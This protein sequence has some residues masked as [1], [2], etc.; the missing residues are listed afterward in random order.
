MLERKQQSR[1]FSFLLAFPKH[2]ALT[3]VKY[4]ARHQLFRFHQFS[5]RSVLENKIANMSRYRYI[6]ASMRLDEEQ[7]LHISRKEG[8]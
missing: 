1:Y 3:F 2:L 4:D 8:S 7:L 6:A 5:T